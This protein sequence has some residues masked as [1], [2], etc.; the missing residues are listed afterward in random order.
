[1]GPR[2]SAHQLWKAAQLQCG[3]RCCAILCCRFLILLKELRVP[4]YQHSKT[5]NIS[6]SVYDHDNVSDNDHIG[7]AT[8]TGTD[9]LMTK[10]LAGGAHDEWFDLLAD[11]HFLFLWLCS[12]LIQKTGEARGK[13]HVNVHFHTKHGMSCEY[14]PNHI[15]CEFHVLTNYVRI[16]PHERICLYLHIDGYYDGLWYYSQI[17]QHLSGVRW[18][19]S[20]MLMETVSLDGRSCLLCWWW[21]LLFNIA[22]I[23]IT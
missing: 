15:S 6:L 14:G 23:N 20:L 2:L 8:I 10:I 5:W 18:P 17:Y 22:K 4:V 19:S 13:L 1:M 16:I 21:Y 3:M 12:S 7:R 9:A 11:V